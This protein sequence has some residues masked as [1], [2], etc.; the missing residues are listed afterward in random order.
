MTKDEIL[1]NWEDVSKAKVK[2]MVGSCG[3]GYSK[4]W[5]RHKRNTIIDVM[6][7]I[8][9]KMIGGNVGVKCRLTV[10]GFNDKFQDFDTYVD[11]TS[12][13]GQR[14]V[15]TAAAEKPEFILFSFNVRRTFAKGMAFEDFSA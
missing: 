4:R 2:A 8:V 3:L 12:R 15:N 13:S 9:W 1:D 10:R 14:S 6:W 7:V 5:S 11:V